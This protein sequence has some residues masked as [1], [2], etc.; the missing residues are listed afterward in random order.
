MPVRK[1]RA[2]WNGD[3]SSGNGTM[4]MSNWEGPYTAASRFE[5]GDGTNPE[6]LLAAAHAGCFSMAFANELAKGG[7]APESVETTAHVHLE[8]TNS[9]PAITKVELVTDASV[10]GI[11]E[12]TFQETA[13]S[14]KKNCPVS[15]LFE[16][17]EITVKATL[18]QT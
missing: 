15:K 7:N 1:A 18:T 2:A 14:A 10:P 12:K 4:K 13:E 8:T 9:G 5:N 11:D 3:L 17:A 6:E 16:S